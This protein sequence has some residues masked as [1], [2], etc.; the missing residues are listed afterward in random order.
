[1]DLLSEPAKMLVNGSRGRIIGWA[2]PDEIVL[3]KKLSYM[4]K[5][6]N[7]SK[8]IEAARLKGKGGFNEKTENG[9]QAG[10]RNECVALA[11]Y[12][13]QKHSGIC[14]WTQSMP[15]V[16]FENGREEVIAPSLFR[17]EI[18]GRGICY[19]MQIPLRLAWALSIH[20]AQ[21]MS[22][23]N[24]RINT[25]GC[26]ENGQVHVALSRA[27]SLAGVELVTEVNERQIKTDPLV[28]KF[29][30]LV[31]EREAMYDQKEHIG[32]DR[33]HARESEEEFWIR[34]KE[35]LG[36]WKDIAPTMERT[37]ESHSS[38]RPNKMKH[39]DHRKDI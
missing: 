16:E 1:M 37:F 6:A 26:F 30:S 32:L 12:L 15:K 10:S 20:K 28:A 18:A 25:K 19:R 21:G 14:D 22:L 36:D 13:Y 27:C 3:Q 5:M 33:N 4:E 17:T 2:D 39:S 38:D 29:Y 24:V 9:P 11:F 23:Q 8:L 34:W 7:K 35:V 31:E